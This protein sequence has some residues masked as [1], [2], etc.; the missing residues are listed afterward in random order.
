MTKGLQLLLCIVVFLTFLL[1]LT[2][3]GSV[4][5][6]IDEEVAPLDEGHSDDDILANSS[7]A[8]DDSSST[9]SKGDSEQPEKS[10]VRSRLVSEI[11]LIS[12]FGA[13]LWLLTFCLSSLAEILHEIIS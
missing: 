12:V 7:D 2:S 9:S 8:E 6:S 10:S 13:I 1:T 3:C 11:M 5:S 4:R